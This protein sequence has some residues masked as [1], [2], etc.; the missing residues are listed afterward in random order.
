MGRVDEALPILEN[1]S[2]SWPSDKAWVEWNLCDTYWALDRPDK[3]VEL[4]RAK[5]DQ[6]QVDRYLAAS[7]AKLN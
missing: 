7:Y 2:V 3:I 1:L 6:P 4:L 5:P